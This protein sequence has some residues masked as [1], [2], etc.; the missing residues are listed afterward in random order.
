MAGL[1]KTVI[2]ELADEIISRL[3]IKISQILEDAKDAADTPASLETSETREQ[4]IAWAYHDL[5]S[6][7]CGD[8]LCLLSQKFPVNWENVAVGCDAK[9]DVDTFEQLY[10]F[11]KSQEQ[12][13]WDNLLEI[14]KGN[15]LSAF[16]VR[17]SYES[18][19]SNSVK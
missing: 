18:F 7:G 15:C 9:D 16:F 17:Y 2:D 19:A 14:V 8:A 3:Q 5:A 4:A 6:L 10:E 11:C 1:V 12:P 13:D